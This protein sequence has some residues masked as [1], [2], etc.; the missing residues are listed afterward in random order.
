MQPDKSP[1]FVHRQCG[2]GWSPTVTNYLLQR[3]AAEVPD[4][5]LGWVRGATGW[6]PVDFR[7]RAKGHIPN[8]G[9]GRGRVEL[10]IDY[11]K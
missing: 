7:W 4:R 10:H 2:Q 3:C 6:M 5:P 11:L 1:G 9:R 8:H